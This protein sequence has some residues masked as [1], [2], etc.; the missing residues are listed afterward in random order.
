MNFF[1]FL[2]NMT[3]L[4]YIK[5]GCRNHTQLN[6]FLPNCNLIFLLAGRENK[7]YNG[8]SDRNENEWE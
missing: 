1:E 5:M 6:M 4:I 8:K 2:L 3:K 7:I